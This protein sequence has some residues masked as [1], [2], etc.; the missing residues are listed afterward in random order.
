MRAD[1]LLSILLLLQTRERV[2]AVELAQRLEVSV[3]TI[4]RDVDA[5]SA[6]GIPVWAER[7]RTGGIRLLPGYRTDVTGLTGDEARALFVLAA[8]GTHQAL[9]LGDA[10]GPALRKVMAALPAPYRDDAERTSQRVLVDPVRWMRGEGGDADIG[11][12]QRAVFTDR[13]LH[14]TYRSNG[15]PAPKQYTVDPYGLVSKAGVWYLVA[16][17]DGEPRLFRADRVLAATVTD[18]PA[19]R[20]PGQELADVWAVLRDRVENLHTE[21]RVRCR[22]RLDH[23]DM[24]QSLCAAHLVEPPKLADG[25][26]AEAELSFRALRAVRFLL[27]FGGSVEVLAPPEARTEL[28]RAAREVTALY[29]TSGSHQHSSTV[30]ASCGRIP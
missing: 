6:A 21:V 8:E 14:L 7:G 9:G 2:P 19:R 1:R 15:A 16:D 24:F 28:A 18:E 22:V 26:W 23:L 5:L 11:V 17:R 13:R 10:I 30:D 12:L 3:R 25:T 20:R 29:T 4:Y 27:S